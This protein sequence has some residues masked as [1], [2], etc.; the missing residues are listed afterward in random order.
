MDRSFAL[1]HLRANAC[2]A[3]MPAGALDAFAGIALCQRLA[4]G[5]LLVARGSPAPGVALVLKGAIHAS[6]FSDE[7]HEFAV[8]MLEFDGLWGLAATLDGDGMLRDNRAYQEAEILLLPREPF[9]EI[10]DREP[11]LYRYFV[12]V[13]CQRIRT[14]HAI[15]DELALCALHQRLPR[16]LSAL[17][18]SAAAGEKGV[19]VSQ[20]QEA[21]AAL[22][23][24]SR[25]AVNR[26][27]KQ[28]EARGLLSLGYG[29][30]WV[31]DCAGLRAFW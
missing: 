27:L 24:V 30:I 23:G 31:R 18:A 11:G 19:P 13:L 9:M 16:L 1:A 21:L 2:F 4:R 29:E 20:T 10:I 12:G 7:G 3:A 17:T 22:L 26:E 14:A 6:S 25:H 8:S 15:M 28:L 5:E